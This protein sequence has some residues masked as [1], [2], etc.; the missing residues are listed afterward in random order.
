MNVIMQLLLERIGKRKSYFIIRIK[1][2]I[3]FSD[4]LEKTRIKK[5]LKQWKINNIGI[6]YSTILC[7][8]LL[9]VICTVLL[10]LLLI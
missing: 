2:K 6:I 8:H 1:P 10:L 3:S 7:W 9:P 5:K 4:P